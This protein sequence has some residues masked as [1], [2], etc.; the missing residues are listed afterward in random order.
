MIQLLV[1]GNSVLGVGSGVDGGTSAHDS[2]ERVIH[3]ESTYAVTHSKG[4]SV[5]CSGTWLSR[6]HHH[7]RWSL[8]VLTVTVWRCE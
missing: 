8:E 7:C 5:Q 4:S 2:V 1:L 6:H 3:E